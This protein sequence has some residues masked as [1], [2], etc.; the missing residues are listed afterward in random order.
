MAGTLSVAELSD[1]ANSIATT[2]PI[3]GSAK[4]WVFFNTAGTRTSYYNV[5][6][7]TKNGSGD[8]TVNFSTAL[9]STRY[10]TTIGGDQNGSAR[11]AVTKDVSTKR[12]TTAL[13]VGC[14]ETSSTDVDTS[15]TV[16][17]YCY[18]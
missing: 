14:A 15:I 6:S 11:Y 8:Y 18:D 7:V 5:G 13:R 9:P 3:V 2:V 17:V 10:A 12:T 4:A 16:A 1:S